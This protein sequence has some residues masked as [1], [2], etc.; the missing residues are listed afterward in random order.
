MDKEDLVFLTFIILICICAMFLHSVAIKLQATDYNAYIKPVILIALSFSEIAVCIITITMVIL[1]LQMTVEEYQATLPYFYCVK[2]VYVA[3]HIIMTI[4]YALRVRWNIQYN[5]CKMEKLWTHILALVVFLI[6]LLMITHAAISLKGFLFKFGLFAESS[7]VFMI[8]SSYI[9]ILV[10]MNSKRMPVPARF[11]TEQTNRRKLRNMLRDLRP[12]LFSVPML[13]LGTHLPFAGIPN[14]IFLTFSEKGHMT[15]TLIHIK[16]LL[17]ALGLVT[18]AALYVFSQPEIRRKFRHAIRSFR[19]RRVQPLR[20]Q[21]LQLQASGQG[22][23]SRSPPSTNFIRQEE[24]TPVLLIEEHVISSIE[25]Q[26]HPNPAPFPIED[27][28]S[29]L[30]CNEELTIASNEELKQALSENFTQVPMPRDHSPQTS[31]QQEY[32]RISLPGMQPMKF[33]VPE[34]I[35]LQEL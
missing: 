5:P 7:L 20:V 35:E 16:F 10:L 30:A 17:S 28:K 4:D 1:P 22:R 8:F 29:A 13:I 32:V 14:I 26:E 18:D 12:T 34:T 2:L 24:S 33:V 6:L 11:L 31:E 3:Y 9:Y 21:P 23:Q 25:K 27:P 15:S 19:A